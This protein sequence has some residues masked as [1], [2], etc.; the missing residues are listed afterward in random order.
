ELPDAKL[1]VLTDAEVFGRTKR[2]RRQSK[3]ADSG[4][5]ITDFGDLKEGDY[6]VHTNHGIGRYLGVE[7]LEIA[8][9]HKD[10]LVVKYAGEDK[11]Y[12]P[13]D[14]VDLL[15]RY[16]GVDSQP[17]KLSRLGGNEWVRVKKRVKESVQEMAKGLLELYA[18]RETIQGHAFAPDTVWQAEFEDAFPYEET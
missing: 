4:V 7:T 17:P 1:V 3:S 5:Q 18:E 8:G 11:L 6:V 2:N 15:Q 16:Y 9:A 10:Y 13:T 12:V 14:Q